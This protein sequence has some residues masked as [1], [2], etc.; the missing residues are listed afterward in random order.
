M[1]INSHSTPS[2]MD[3][4][5]QIKAILKQQST[6]TQ[7]LSNPLPLR[8][9]DLVPSCCSAGVESHAKLLKQQSLPPPPLS[10]PLPLR[11]DLVP[12]CCSAGV[13]SHAY[14]YATEAAVRA[15]AAVDP[16]TP[17]AGPRAQLLQCRRGEPR[18]LLC[19]LLKQ[20]SA[21]APPLS[22]PLPLRRDLVPSCCSAGV[23]SH[24]YYYAVRPPPPLSTPL[25]LRRDLVPSC[26][27]AGVESH[28]YYYANLESAVLFVKAD[29]PSSSRCLSKL[30]KQ[31]WAPPPPSTPLPLR[32]DLVPSCC[33]AGVESHDYY[34]GNYAIQG[35]AKMA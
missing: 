10:P 12:S 31:Q 25:P 27:S 26:C 34:Y 2:Y 30:L 7:Q 29:T 1:S 8:R 15:P 13:E 16:A 33:S 23:E 28:A 18:L 19:K 6:P 32:R 20:Q 21:P 3:R 17:A 14:Y 24:A 9:A 22:T 35:V 5:E 11:R 4:A